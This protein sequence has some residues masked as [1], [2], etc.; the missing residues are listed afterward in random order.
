M[1]LIRNFYEGS[2]FIYGIAMLSMYAI[3]AI[4]SFRGVLR[5]KR[6]DRNTDYTC[7]LNSELAPGIS[8]I[9]PAYNE[10]VTIIQNVRS[11]LTLNYSR[12][13]VIIVNDGSTDDT[14]QKLINEFELEEVEFAYNERIKT[15]PVKRLFKSTN[16]AYDKLLVIDKVNGRARPTL[17]MQG[18]TR[19]PTTTSSVRTWIAS[20]KKILF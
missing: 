20:L 7:M 15:Q 4:L 16:V 11:L 8:V 10:G 9:A 17:P 3:L 18:S 13:E 14:L 1:E 5:F 19:R 6:K 2:I 12:F